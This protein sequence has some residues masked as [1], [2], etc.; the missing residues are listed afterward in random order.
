[1]AREGDEVGTQGE[2]RPRG[3]GGGGAPGGHTARAARAA[4]G[5]R[6]PRAARGAPGDRTARA[7]RAAP[8]DRRPRAARLASMAR[9]A[10]MDQ[11]ARRQR[12]PALLPVSAGWPGSRSRRPSPRC[13]CS[14]YPVT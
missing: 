3:M 11:T 10:G 9:V 7:A 5:D 8:G 14:W 12:Q 4:P 6:R 1:M 13:W 2:S